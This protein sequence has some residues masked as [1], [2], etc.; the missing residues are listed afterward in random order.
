[1][2]VVLIIHVLGALIVSD[3]DIIG[4]AS[5]GYV[6]LGV[7]FDHIPLPLS[8]RGSVRSA[9]STVRALLGLE[10]LHPHHQLL[11]VGNC[12]HKHVEFEL[13][14]SLRCLALSLHRLWGSG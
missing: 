9:Q 11:H 2:L 1:M 5:N 6:E 10:G 4:V 8:D 7:L 14:L 3:V 13:L 12:F